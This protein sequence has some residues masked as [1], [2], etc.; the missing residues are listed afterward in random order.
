VARMDIDSLEAGQLLTDAVLL[1]AA[2]SLQVDRRGQSYY[3]LTLNAE[4]GRQIEA[5]VWADNIAEAIEPGVGL[6]LLARV[7]EYRGKKQ[8]NVQRYKVIV[9]DQYDFSSFV[10]RAEID[11]EAAFETLFDWDRDE[12]VN[13]RLRALMGQFHSNAPFAA[14]FKQSPAA[15]FH[16][17]NYTGGLLEHTLDVWNLADRI[18]GLYP[19][20]LDRDLLLCGAA[21][22][23]VGKVNAYRLTTGVSQRTDVGELLDHIF[24]SAS[25]VSNMWDAAVKGAVPAAEA[26]QAA[27][28]KA[29]LLHIILSHHGTLEWGS[30][31]LPRTAEALLIHHCDVISAGLHTCFNAIAQTPQG[32]SWSNP[33]YIMDAQR[34]LF[35]RHEEEE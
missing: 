5:K 33:V 29:L 25:M 8:L 12:F 15:S 16:H 34:R 23:D 13:P 27:Q 22:H 24:I 20:R 9:P 17:H 14:Q 30:P 35:V 26:A 3:T 28:D 19:R 11:I 18:S 1:V 21:L 4:G 32:E 2:A 6:E 7:D 10:R 31:V